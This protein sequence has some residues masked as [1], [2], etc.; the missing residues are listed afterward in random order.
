MSTPFYI[1][2]PIYYVNAKPHL[3]HAYTTL[4][5]DVATRFHD[6]CGCESFFLTGTDEHG[7]KIVQAAEK[8]G[9]SPGN[10]STGS[11][12]C[13][14]RYG[15]SSTST[16]ATSSAPP[17]PGILPLSKRFCRKSTMPG[18]FISVNMKG[19]TA[20]AVNAFTPKGNLWRGNAP[21]MKSN[22]RSLKNPI[23]FSK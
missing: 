6:M 22:P 15:P 17:M 3:G 9:C 12:L 1:T 10:T 7:D 5:A 4:V 18:T 20:S 11:V 23:I 2:T 19:F 21:T 13:S 14:D 8:E 16:T